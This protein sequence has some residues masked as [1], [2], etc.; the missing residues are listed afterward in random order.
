MAHFARVTNGVIASQDDIHVV[1]NDV[2]L[3]EH[4]T[5]QESLGQE[6][7]AGLWGG[8]PSDYIQVSYNRSDFR[9]GYPAVGYSWDGQVFAPPVASSDEVTPQ[10]DILP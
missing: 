2:L 9:G 7:L 6:F 4:G 3:D 8:N 1:A 5:E 10:P